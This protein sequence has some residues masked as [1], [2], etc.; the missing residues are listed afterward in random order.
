MIKHEAVS[1]ESCLI[2]HCT[3]SHLLEINRTLSVNERFPKIVY[4]YLIHS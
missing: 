4:F 2:I 1:F 3:F